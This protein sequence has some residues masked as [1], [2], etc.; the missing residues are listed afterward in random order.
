[1]LSIRLITMGKPQCNVVCE[2]CG[3]HIYFGNLHRT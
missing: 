2:S 3:E 1:M